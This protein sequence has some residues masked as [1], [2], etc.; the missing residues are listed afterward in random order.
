[1]G[2][3]GQPPPAPKGAITATLPSAHTKC[4]KEG[5][6]NKRGVGVGIRGVPITRP[7][8]HM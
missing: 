3:E 4:D 5:E 7:H 1:M 2:W 8:D 6:R